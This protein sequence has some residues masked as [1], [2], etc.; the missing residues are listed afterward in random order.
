MLDGAEVS[1]RDQA[2]ASRQGQMDYDPNDDEVVISDE[3]IEDEP[4]MAEVKV[5]GQVRYVDQAKIDDGGGIDT[6]QK[7]LA[8]NEGLQS[9][10]NERK[11]L[12]QQQQNL[13]QQRATFKANRLSVQDGIKTTSVPSSDERTNL[14]KEYHQALFDGEDDKAN[15]LFLEVY[16]EAQQQA[17]P[18]INTQEIVERASNFTR[19]QIAVE[20]KQLE[21][22]QA[23]DTFADDHPIV[24]SDTGLFNMASDRT[25][26]LQTEHPDWSPSK[27][28]DEAAKHVEHWYEGITGK[29]SVIDK[30]ADKRKISAVKT[31]SGRSTPKPPPKQQTPSDYITKLRQQRGLEI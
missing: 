22:R 18:E 13:E 30:I 24:A 17:T 25:I 15:K 31:A 28:I 10:A 4:K 12:K 27:V 21:Q 3:V 26:T 5:N 14:V 16:P 8:A 29:S 9:L 23:N 20:Q 2:I 19:Q 6:Y 1:P 7:Q 11:L